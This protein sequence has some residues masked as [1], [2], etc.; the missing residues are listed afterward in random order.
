MKLKVY[1][2]FSFSLVFVN[3]KHF[4]YKS[5]IPFVVKLILSDAD[6]TEAVGWAKIQG[7]SMNLFPSLCHV[8]SEENCLASFLKVRCEDNQ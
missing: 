8:S 7:I 5:N 1:L 2:S 3:Y 6:V 4:T